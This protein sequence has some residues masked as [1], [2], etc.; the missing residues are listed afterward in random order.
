MSVASAYNSILWSIQDPI[1]AFLQILHSILS[2][3]TSNDAFD[4]WWTTNY[5]ISRLPPASTYNPISFPLGE[6][7]FPFSSL[8]LLRGPFPFLSFL[9]PF[10]LTNI[11]EVEQTSTFPN[12]LHLLDECC[13]R[14][15]AGPKMGL[16]SKFGGIFL[17]S[18]SSEI[19]PPLFGESW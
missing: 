13:W 1:P 10:L 19:S 8:P 4:S 16:H 14:A 11:F 12:T 7:R 18:F 5:T 2:S 17:T 3:P 6:E 9:P 15:L